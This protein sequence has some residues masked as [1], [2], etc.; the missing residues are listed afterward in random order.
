MKANYKPISF[1][2][3]NLLNVDFQENQKEFDYPWHYHQ[4]YELTY[5]P[6]G[7]G[8]RYVGN[9]VENYIEDDLVLLGSNLPH[10]WI[11]ETNSSKQSPNAV[12]IYLKEEFLDKIWMQSHEFGAIKNLLQSSNRGI[13]FHQDVAKK[14]KDKC[15]TLHNL[16]P[17]E[18]FTHVLQ[19]LDEL[20]QSVDYRFL[21]EHDFS[22]ALN[23]H[24]SNRINTIYRYIDVHYRE[25]ISL[26]DIAAEVY[27]SPKYFS[28][29]FSKVMKKPFFEFLNEY[30]ISK[31]CKLLI[32]TDKQIS[33]IC[34]DS[35]FES[36]PFFYRQFKKFKQCQPKQYRSYHLKALSGNA[37]TP[38]DILKR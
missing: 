6:S 10:C 11:D 17:L 12:V 36:I 33:D 29:F 7:Q 20:S 4:E 35:G 19:I 18:K 16:R 37:I 15:L 5:I 2:E 24:S 27:I 23:S 1:D 28:R 8:L 21:S 9:S 3:S 14:L 26:D 25:K 34:Y 38:I 32:E 13:K 31:A 22:S 30:R